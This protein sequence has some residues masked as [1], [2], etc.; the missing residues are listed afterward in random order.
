MGQR[1]TPQHTHSLSSGIEKGNY[2]FFSQAQNK[3]Q[4][5]ASKVRESHLPGVAKGEIFGF[6]GNHSEERDRNGQGPWTQSFSQTPHCG[7][8]F[9]DF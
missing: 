6:R 8:P 2:V 7:E 5:T 3:L 1:P 9:P 4:I